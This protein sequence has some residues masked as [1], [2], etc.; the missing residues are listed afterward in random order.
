VKKLIK[1]QSNHGHLVL[2]LSDNVNVPVKRG[3]KFDIFCLNN[4]D[5]LPIV[6]DIWGK[7]VKSADPIDFLNI[8]LKGI[9]KYF[10]VW[11][12]NVFEHLKKNKNEL[13]TELQ[14]MNSWKNVLFCLLAT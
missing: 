5:F 13:K 11:G 1:D 2:D 14:T 10:K 3:Y 7:S 6:A 9:K 8:K 4:K 12:S